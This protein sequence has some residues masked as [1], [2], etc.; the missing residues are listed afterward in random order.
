MVT[1]SSRYAPA[2]D[3]QSK[4]SGRLPNS[5][6]AQQLGASAAAA[7]T[8]RCLAFRAVQSY[9][10]KTPMTSI[11]LLVWL[12]VLASAHARRDVA[13]GVLFPDPD[14]DAWRLSFTQDALKDK[15][16]HLPGAPPGAPQLYSG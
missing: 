5:H 7:S 10:I 3:Q 1:N 16:D 11:R 6:A 8:A 14:G 12:F 13:A 15:V 4:A 9:P 2:D